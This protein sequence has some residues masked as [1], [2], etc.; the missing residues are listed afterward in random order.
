MRLKLK[1]L[2]FKVYKQTVKPANDLLGGYS[3]SLIFIPFLSLLVTAFIPMDL[4][5]A[6]MILKSFA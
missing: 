3:N 1:V 4:F 2:D 6:L 5:G